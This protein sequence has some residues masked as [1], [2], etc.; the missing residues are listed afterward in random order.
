VELARAGKQMDTKVG[1]EIVEDESVPS[2]TTTLP[3]SSDMTSF[4]VALLASIQTT[5]NLILSHVTQFVNDVLDER[6]GVKSHLFSYVIA[7]VLYVWTKGYRLESI[8]QGLHEQSITSIHSYFC[9]DLAPTISMVALDP[10]QDVTEQLKQL[11][12]AKP[13]MCKSCGKE[14]VFTYV[15]AQTRSADEGMTTF[16]TCSLC[17]RRQKLG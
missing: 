2:V 15:L 1:M 3:A 11:S 14:S 13:Q 12:N 5:Q 10:Y 8:L 16:M 6:R 4:L 7:M 17:G 9:F